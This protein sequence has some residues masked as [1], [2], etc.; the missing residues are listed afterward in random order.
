MSSRECRI[1]LRSEVMAERKRKSFVAL[2]PGG[3]FEQSWMT[4]RGFLD[5]NQVLHL[6][7]A[8]EK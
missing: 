6:I 7:D 2:G 3:E 1:G 5:C 4:W 8:E